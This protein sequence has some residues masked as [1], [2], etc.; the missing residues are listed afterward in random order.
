MHISTSLYGTQVYSLRFLTA[1]NLAKL[2]DFVRSSTE[3]IMPALLPHI[4]LTSHQKFLIVNSLLSNIAAAM[5][6]C[7]IDS[8]SFLIGK[9]A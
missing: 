5:R 9:M 2:S 4:R 8:S 3:L 6:L 1:N 7:T